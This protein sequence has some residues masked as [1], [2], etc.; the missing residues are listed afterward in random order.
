VL[1]AALRTGIDPNG[2]ELSYQMP[3][4]PIGRMDVEELRAVFEYLTHMFALNAPPKTKTNGAQGRRI[5]LS[6]EHFG[7]ERKPAPQ[8]HRDLG[9]NERPPHHLEN[10]D[11][12]QRVGTNPIG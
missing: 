9:G 7:W 11:V 3:W 8:R 1:I 5:A 12:Q 10:A 4:R 2:H 6:A